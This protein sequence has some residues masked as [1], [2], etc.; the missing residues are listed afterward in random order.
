MLNKKIEEALNAQV[1]AELWSAYLYLSMSMDFAS[2]GKPGLLTDNV[3][4][5]EEQEHALKILNYIISRGGKP[6]LKPIGEVKTS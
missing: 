6:I 1:N 4:F 3:Q 2:S 5:Q